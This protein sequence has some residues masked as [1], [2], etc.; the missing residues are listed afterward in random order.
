MFV[1]GMPVILFLH[2][3]RVQRNGASTARAVHRPFDANVIKSRT[4]TFGSSAADCYMALCPAGRTCLA[5]Y[6]QFDALIVHA[7]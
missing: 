1:V 6:A 2:A 7:S 4:L 3:F 5:G